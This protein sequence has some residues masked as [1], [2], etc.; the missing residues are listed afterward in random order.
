V[1]GTLRPLIDPREPLLVGRIDRSLDVL[2]KSLNG[3]AGPGRT[4]PRWDRL[5][6]AEK[7]LVSGQTAAARRKLAYVPRWSIRARSCRSVAIGECRRNE[8]A[9]REL[10][11]GGAALGAGALASRI[12]AAR[13]PRRARRAARPEPPR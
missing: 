8:R 3:L 4:M 7:T 13:A 5:P 6:A 12:P 10:L 11:I 2:E 9:T 1:I